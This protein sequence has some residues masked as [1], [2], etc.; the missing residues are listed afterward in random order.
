[1]TV[2]ESLLKHLPAPTDTTGPNISDAFMTIA[3]PFR[4]VI[5][6]APTSAFLVQRVS[7]VCTCSQM[8]MLVVDIGKPRARPAPSVEIGEMPGQALM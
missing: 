1:V 4:L 3:V 8:R 5:F 6:W 2:V 7:V